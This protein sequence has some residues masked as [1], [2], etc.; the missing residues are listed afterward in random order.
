M[1]YLK[2]S[3]EKIVKYDENDMASIYCPVCDHRNFTVIFGKTGRTTLFC[4]NDDF[5]L[6]RKTDLTFKAT[7]A[8]FEKMSDEH[9]KTQ[10]KNLEIL[11][12]KDLISYIELIENLEVWFNKNIKK[13]QEVLRCENSN[14]EEPRTTTAIVYNGFE[15]KTIGVCAVCEMDIGSDL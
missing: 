15:P 4:S 5:S 7:Y 1:K 6:T 13:D 9:K 11:F 2:I 3:I 14:C 12:K 8:V 10:N